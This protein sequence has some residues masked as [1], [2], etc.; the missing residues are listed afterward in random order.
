M[1]VAAFALVLVAAV[2]HALWNLAAK[3]A[4]GNIGLFWL[5]LCVA[6]LLLAPAALWLVV[7]S[8]DFAGL[9]Y[10][11]ATGLCHALY[12]GLLAAA[13]R[14]GE[15]SVV[16]PLARGTGVAGTAAVAWVILGEQ[17]SALGALGIASVC[18]GVL[19]L[20]RF[21]PRHPAGSRSYLLA[22]LV[23]LTSTCYALVDKLGVGLVHPVVY[24]AGLG[25]AAAVFLA[26]LVLWKYRKDTQEAWRDRKGPCLLVGLGSMGAY[27]L[28]LCAFQQADASYVVAVREFGIVVGTVLG[29]LVLKEPLTVP[30]GMAILAITVGVVLVKVA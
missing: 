12:F 21:G 11:A 14:H 27:L 20:G 3:R 13:Y 26:P 7:P 22:L 24:L 18:F 17:I 8:R 16:Y 2:L 15:M 1:S 25:F 30:K 6:S 10:M 4:S 23:G 29:V 19:L 9:P 28:I 5:G